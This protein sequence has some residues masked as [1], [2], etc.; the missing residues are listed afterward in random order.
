LNLETE[1]IIERPVLK[2]LKLKLTRISWP[3]HEYDSRR[4]AAQ[5]IANATQ[6]NNTTSEKIE[7]S[8]NRGTLTVFWPK[9][10]HFLIIQIRI[11]TEISRNYGMQR[12]HWAHFQTR[13]KKICTLQSGL[14]YNCACP[15]NEKKE[16]KN[17]LNYRGTLEI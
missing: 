14:Q 3:I 16:K 7:V 1:I 6:N 9:F 15:E 5:K 13:N 8:P 11:K 10:W 2:V 17:K 4:V 12:K